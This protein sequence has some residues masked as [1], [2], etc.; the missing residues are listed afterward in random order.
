MP[1]PATRRQFY[2]E[3][4]AL[5]S[6]AFCFDRGNGARELVFGGVVLGFE[7]V[8]LGFNSLA[9]LLDT[10]IGI[11]PQ[12]RAEITI[13]AAEGL[14]DLHPIPRFFDDPPPRGDGHHHHH[15]YLRE[16]RQDRDSFPHMVARAARAIDRQDDRFAVGGVLFKFRQRFAAP[17]IF[18]FALAL[19]GTTHHVHAEHSQAQRHQLAVAGT[20]EHR[21]RAGPT[22]DTRRD[23]MG[24]QHGVS[25][26]FALGP[27]FRP[28]IVVPARAA[29]V[30]EQQ[31]HQRD[32]P[33]NEPRGDFHK[34][35]RLGATGVPPVGSVANAFPSST[36]GTPV[37]PEL[38]KKLARDAQL[39]AGLR[40]QPV[41]HRDLI[42]VRC[43]AGERF[44]K[45]LLGGSAIN[46][47]RRNRPAGKDRNH[48]VR[49]L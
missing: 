47:R 44:G 3:V 4:G 42:L 24:V 8:E 18:T 37:T 45:L 26:R 25:V 38:S 12:Q 48:I 20:R 31:Q 22:V 2:R 1:T 7:L 14:G 39:T 17:F 36:G 9:I 30:L 28:R 41:T 16:L 32:G 46:L 35:P 49:H 33:S 13:D 6:A 21:P 23:L 5:G 27:E 40:D 34:A 15:R 19:A 29:G 43:L 10:F 11:G